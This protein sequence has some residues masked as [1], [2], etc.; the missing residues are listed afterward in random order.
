VAPDARVAQEEIFG[1]VLVTIP[2]DTLDE[3]L[4]IANSVRYGLTASVYTRDLGLAHRFVR[5]VQA[6]MVWVNDSS[7]HL[8]GLPFGGIKDSGVG[9]EE[10]FDEL[11]SY[12]ESKSVSMRF[13]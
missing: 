11:L 3:A 9:R 6:G 12:T 5:E 2:F 10:G 7:N 1:P 4:R 8:P 13:A